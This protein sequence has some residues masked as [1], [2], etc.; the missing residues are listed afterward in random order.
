MKN[1]FVL[2]VVFNA[3]TASGQFSAFQLEKPAFKTIPAIEKKMQ[4][5]KFEYNFAIT[6]AKNYFPGS[7]IY[8]LANPLVY[9]RPDGN[10]RSEVSYFYSVPDNIVRLVEYSFDMNATDTTLLK[11]RFEANDSAFS[12]YFKKEAAVT[13]EFHPTWWQQMA[14][15]ENEDIHIK[16]FMVIGENTYRLRV[17]VSWKNKQAAMAKKMP[18]A[19]KTER[20]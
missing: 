10:Y 7:A 3:A 18:V 17:L 2:C 6:V 13:H 16:Q 12:A 11:Q 4:G 9:Y 8:K 15:W 14:I 20:K 1:L 19:S 5:R